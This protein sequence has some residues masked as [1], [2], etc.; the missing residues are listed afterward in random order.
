MAAALARV[1]VAAER[2]GTAALDR[3]HGLYLLARE[4][5]GSPEGLASG[6]EDL[7]HVEARPLRRGS[8]PAV[9]RV[10]RDEPGYPSGFP[11]LVRR[12][13]SGLFVRRTLSALTWV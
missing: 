6:P 8:A 12:M 9:D 11:S 5:V 1:D 7:G 4:D 3:P 13:S 2:L 10:H